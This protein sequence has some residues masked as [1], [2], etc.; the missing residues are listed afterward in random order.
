MPEAAV[1]EDCDS[2]ARKDDVWT[3]SSSFDDKNE[4]FAESQPATVECGPQPHLGR[5][6]LARVSL[7]DA[8]RRCVLWDGI[9]NALAAAES[10]RSAAH[11]FSPCS[12][13]RCHTLTVY[14]AS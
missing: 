11:N 4:V 2:D 10:N 14:Y 6:V 12:R 7:A 13:L 1:D 9:G 3:N 5:G 8:R